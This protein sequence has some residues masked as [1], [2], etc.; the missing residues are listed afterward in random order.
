MRILGPLWGN[1]DR[2]RVAA[3]LIR[4][5]LCIGVDRPLWRAAGESF[6]TKVTAYFTEP[7]SSKLVP[8]STMWAGRL[9][10]PFFATIHPFFI[11]V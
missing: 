3:P 4:V 1:Q 8:L 7:G 11:L 2:S 10:P 5:G 6:E 9:S